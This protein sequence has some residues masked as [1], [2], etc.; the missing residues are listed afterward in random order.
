MPEEET[1]EILE[2]EEEDS[3][4]ETTTYK[5][6]SYGADY[7]I[8]VLYQKLGEGSIVIPEF[9]RNYVWKLPQASKLVESFLIGL[10]VPPIF[11]AK[12]RETQKLIVVDGNQRLRTIKGFKDKIFPKTEQAFRLVDVA[13]TFMGKTYD[14]LE[15]NM[16]R[17][18]DDSVLR[19]IIVE[20]VEPDDNQSIYHLFQRLNSGGTILTN[21]EIRNCIFSGSLN[22]LLKRLN[23]YASWRKLYKK[24]RPDERMRDV[25]L[26]LRF[27]ALFYDGNNY[28]K[29]MNEF[30]NTFMVKNRK[31]SRDQTIHMENIFKQTIDFIS[32]SL[33]PESL[34]PRG[35][36]N[37]AVFDSV[38]YTVA[39][40]RDTLKP[41]I[42]Y[43]TVKSL[44]N[45]ERYMKAVREGTTDPEVIKLRMELA[46]TYLVG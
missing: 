45:D 12:D 30:L 28:E 41:N 16:K 19:S 34:R 32:D 35:N 31:I 3:Q 29:P 24:E 33:T 8:Q 11:L 13:H 23:G 20:Q 43:E 6:I 17:K 27:F 5:V 40:Y 38:A 1:I 46:K 18:F 4:Q 25:E 7:T 44:F 2:S 39:K 15:G 36:L 21:Q 9:Q 10:P 14:E 42:S 26:I 37:V 22:E